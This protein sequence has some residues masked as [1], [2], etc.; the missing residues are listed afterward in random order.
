MGPAFTGAT[1]VFRFVLRVR[2]AIAM[3]IPPI[4]HKSDIRSSH[5]QIFSYERFMA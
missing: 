1:D 2:R 4:A 5:L 3:N